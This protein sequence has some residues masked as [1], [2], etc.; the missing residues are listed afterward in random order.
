VIDVDYRGSRGYGSDFRT[1]VPYHLGGKDLDDINLV[2]DEL[3]RRGVVDRARVGIYGGSYGGF[4]ALMALFTAPERW[5]CGAALRSVT[6]WRTYYPEYTQ[7]RLG[8]PSTHAEAYVRSSPIDQVEGLEDPLLVLHGMRDAN[9]FAQ[10]SIR[11]IEALID[12]GHDFEAMLY[13]SQGHAFADG[14]HWLDEYRR[15]ER[16]LVRHLGPPTATARQHGR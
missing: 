1:D 11:L 12:G 5:A 4:L 6:D 2:V 8:R 3:A 15:I 7:P 16:F 10:D 9:V 13:P 14:P